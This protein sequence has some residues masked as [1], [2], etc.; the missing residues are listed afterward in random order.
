MPVLYTT[1]FSFTSLTLLFRLP[2]VCGLPKTLVPKCLHL[3]ATLVPNDKRTDDH[4]INVIGIENR[5][6][7]LRGRRIT[8]ARSKDINKQ[9]PVKRRQ[10]AWYWYSVYSI[11]NVEYR[12]C[13]GIHSLHCTP[14][15]QRRKLFRQ[16]G[17]TSYKQDV[18]CSVC[19]IGYFSSRLYHDQSRAVMSSDI[20]DWLIY[21]KAKY[22]I[23]HLL[24]YTDVS[25][26][27]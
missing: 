21:I 22:C 16:K 14:R 11:T 27:L 24:H 6:A 4:L 23:S 26:S 7:H 18:R 13:C 3:C 5:E 20:S 1:P 8:L 17:E 10:T 19:E 2:S 25:W 15:K 12:V 9:S